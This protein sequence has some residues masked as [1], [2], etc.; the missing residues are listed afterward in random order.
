MEI[1]NVR[2]PENHIDTQ[3]QLESHKQ[4]HYNL[5]KSLEH[6]EQEDLINT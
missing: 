6:L 3:K 4:K 5:L 1:R 2:K